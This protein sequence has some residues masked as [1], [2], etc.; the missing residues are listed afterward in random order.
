VQGPHELCGVAAVGVERVG[1][2]P[3]LDAE[4]GEEGGVVGGEGRRG[5]AE[6]GIGFGRGRW[7]WFGCGDF[8]WCAWFFAAWFGR[9]GG[10][11]LIA[12]TNTRHRRSIGNTAWFAGIRR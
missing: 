8:D 10:G 5:E 6:I 3:A 2:E 1:Q 12:Q 11:R 9:L 7:W 4:E